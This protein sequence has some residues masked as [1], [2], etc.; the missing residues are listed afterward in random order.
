MK[1]Y[2]LLPILLL[3]GW[4]GASVTFFG[5]ETFVREQGGPDTFFRTFTLCRW[6]GTFTLHVVN[7]DLD[8]ENRVSSATIKVNGLE[9]VKQSDLSPKVAGLDIQLTGM[10]ETNSIDIRMTSNPGSKLTLEVT[11]EMGC[12]LE[13]VITKPLHASI[14]PAPWVIVQGTLSSSTPDVGVVVNGRAAEVDLAHQ[15]YGSDPYKWAVR[16]PVQEG[17]YVVAAKAKDEDGNEDETAIDLV[18]NPEEGHFR[19]IVDPEVAYDIPRTDIAFEGMEGEFAELQLDYEGDG[20]VDMVYHN[21]PPSLS[22]GYW[23][24]LYF[25]KA[26]YRNQAGAWFESEA[27]VARPLSFYLDQMLR[28][29][30][31]AFRQAIASG[32]MAKIQTYYT[33]S[34]WQRHAEAI[35]ITAQNGTLQSASEAMAAIV[36]GMYFRS[37]AEYVILHDYNGHTYG[38][39]LYFSKCVDGI[40][41]IDEY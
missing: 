6:E 37:Y 12:G 24:G 19:I 9:V 30:W 17:P 20:R 3:G 39:Y 14:V 31:E 4:L 23:M 26:R 35:Q 32:D 28:R 41:R 5:P 21:P 25:P 38:N 34:C 29:K 16:V 36:R 7:G 8:G 10:L 11:G 2:L 1:H 22:Y 33:T 18:V 27:L 40:W 15:G 13:L